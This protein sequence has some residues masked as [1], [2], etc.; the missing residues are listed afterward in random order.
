[1]STKRTTRINHVHIV[2]LHKELER[3]KQDQ[4][5]S[6]RRKSCIIQATIDHYKRGYTQFEYS[7]G[8][9]TVTVVFSTPE[10]RS[11]DVR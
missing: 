9:N 11:E 2:T 3:L 7:N 6:A 10:E 4:S 1:M 5:D 8:G